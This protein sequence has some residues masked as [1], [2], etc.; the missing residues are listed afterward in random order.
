MRSDDK[1]VVALRRAVPCPVV[2]TARWRLVGRPGVLVKT[3]EFQDRGLRDAFVVAL[4]GE[5][6]ETGA[7]SELLLRGLQVTVTLVRDGL[8]VVTEIEREHARACDVLFR[9]IVY[10]ATHDDDARGA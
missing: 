5:E 10:S 3:Y 7:S 4:L 8:G 2:V 6:A 1:P 9:E